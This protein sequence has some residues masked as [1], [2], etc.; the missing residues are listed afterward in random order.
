MRDFIC[1][2]DVAIVRRLRYVHTF[3]YKILLACDGW[4]KS[5]DSLGMYVSSLIKASRSLTDG[6]NYQ[7]F[8]TCTYFHLQETV[9]V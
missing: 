3:T 9:S 5:S 1:L 2:T 7:I 8:W 4:C 6:V